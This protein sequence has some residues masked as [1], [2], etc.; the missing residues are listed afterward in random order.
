[1]TRGSSKYRQILLPYGD[2]ER[3]ISLSNDFNR[4]MQRNHKSK[5][6]LFF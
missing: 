1:M 5:G 4:K 3:M 6:F 2:G